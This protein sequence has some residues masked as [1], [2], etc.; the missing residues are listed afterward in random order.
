MRDSYARQICNDCGHERYDHLNMAGERSGFSSSSLPDSCT[1]K[2]CKCE[3]F[4]E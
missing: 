2:M 3:E 1:W 4:K